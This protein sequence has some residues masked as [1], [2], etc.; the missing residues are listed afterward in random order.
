MDKDTYLELK[1]LFFKHHN[2]LEKFFK[3][4]TGYKEEI[5][6]LKAKADTY[7]QDYIQAKI[8]E[9]ENSLRVTGQ[10]YLEGFGELAE[11]LSVKLIEV[12]NRPIMAEWAGELTHYIELIN[13][14]LVEFKEAKQINAV[15]EGDQTALRLLQRAYDKS[16]T[17]NGKIEDLIYPHDLDSLHEQLRVM[18]YSVFIQ[19]NSVNNLGRMLGKIAVWFGVKDFDW[20]IDPRNLVN[21]M[22]ESAGLP[23]ED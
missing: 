20:V 6:E 5:A 11:M 13:T 17:P 10:Q 23:V 2:H 14:G 7:S 8:A 21:V 15:F 22:R 3:T 1:D 4:R 18:A 9:V 16:S 12:V 19:D